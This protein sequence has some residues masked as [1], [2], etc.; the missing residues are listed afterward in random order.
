MVEIK[1]LILDVKYADRLQEMALLFCLH[2]TQGPP[3]EP[4]EVGL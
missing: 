3:N 4:G 2:F 1:S